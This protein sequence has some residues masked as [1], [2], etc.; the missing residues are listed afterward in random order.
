M[1]PAYGLALASALLLS[2]SLIAHEAGHALV[3]RRRGIP[4]T[5]IDLW[6]L[7][8]RGEAAVRPGAAA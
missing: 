6:L 3:A 5:G 8:W 4:V 7:G 1:A 2:L